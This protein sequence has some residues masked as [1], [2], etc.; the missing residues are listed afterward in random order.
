[1]STGYTHLVSEGKISF[2]KFVLSCARGMGYCIMQRDDDMSVPPKLQSI[3]NSY[4]SDRLKELFRE[5]DKL[6]NLSDKEIL[7]K[8]RAS[9]KTSIDS[10]IKY[11][12]E[13]EVQEVNYKEMI[14]KVED[15]SPPTSEHNS[16]KEFMLKQLRESL[17][18][19]CNGD[20]WSRSIATKEN[21]LKNLKSGKLIRLER[22]MEIEGE[23]KELNQKIE[24]AR[25]NVAKQ[26]NY[27]M[28]LY[29][30]LEIKYKE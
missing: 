18:F 1:M 12:K 6:N 5:K 24:K 19:D 28:S 2:E 16:L 23:I 10:Y 26:N 25:I 27:I 14:K 15:W 29:N 22:L 9:I 17:E 4:D 8:E 21:K 7:E 3:D 13:R 30:N 11:K 20:Y